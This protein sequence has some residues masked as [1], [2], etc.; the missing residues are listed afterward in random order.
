M[1]AVDSLMFVTRR[2][3]VTFVR[4]EGSWLYDAQGRAY[5]DFVQGWAVNSL[6][7]APVLLRQALATQASQ[8]INVSPAYY[9]EAMRRLADR[10]ASLSGLDR[11]FFASSGAEANEGAIKLARKWGAL[12]KG[13]AFEIVVFEDAFHGRTLAT[14][15]ASGKPGWDRLFEPKVPG[16]V[17]VPRNDID[18]VAR[19]LGPRT[20]AVMLE[21]IQGES[22]VIPFSTSF[23]RR[24]RELTDESGVL[25][26][27]DEI[28]T[29]IGR[30]G[31]M[32]CYEHLGICPDI[33]TLGKGIGGGVPLAALLA[34]EDV[35]V[36]EAGDQG[37]TFGG[38]ALMTAAGDAVVAEVSRPE[39]LGGV[40]AAGE[41]M[42]Q[43]LRALSAD[44][45]LG[46]VRG[47]GLLAALDLGRPTGAA[48]VQAALANGLLVNSPRPGCLRFMPALNVT[49]AEIDEMLVRLR[50]AL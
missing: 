43:C 22:G 29:G 41:H 6:G 2:P 44:K 24:L 39:F 3:D 13:G 30:T 32:F 15:S 5:L 46:E 37:G 9:H 23:M 1:P 45:G 17:R 25:L 21:P 26:V 48:A 47:C 8:V 28:Q 34:R 40:R 16:F 50:A 33:L 11:V 38:N 42:M 20:C 49:H 27:L 12:K 35:S 36:F 18:A 7:H 4:G 19:A 10:L 31:R 14:M